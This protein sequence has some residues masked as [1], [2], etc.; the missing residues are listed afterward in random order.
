MRANSYRAMKV[1]R[2][3]YG[4]ISAE[5]S[6]TKEAK[7]NTLIL[8]LAV[9]E[10]VTLEMKA[11]EDDLQV[12]ERTA[13]IEQALH[14]LEW[15]KG[16]VSDDPGE[17]VTAEEAGGF[18]GLFIEC[19]RAGIVPDS[20]VVIGSEADAKKEMNRLMA[21]LEKAGEDAHE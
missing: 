18:I 11:Y 8:S 16:R 1:Y 6:Q 19:L 2:E 4:K 12:T 20:C 15:L 17:Y 9:A 5:I 13:Y 21:E 7:G 3:A 14:K 10:I